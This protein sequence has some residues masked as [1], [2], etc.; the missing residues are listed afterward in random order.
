MSNR[1]K[2]AAD[3][4]L[5]VMKGSVMEDIAAIR[6]QIQIFPFFFLFFFLFS[7]CNKNRLNPGN[8]IHKNQPHLSDQP[9]SGL[10]PDTCSYHAVWIEKLSGLYPDSLK[11][12]VVVEVKWRR[13]ENGRFE[14]RGKW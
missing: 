3:H 10:W 4:S 12:W 2:V 6:F 13:V 8:S 5:A 14:M 9:S 11:T 7:C 1:V